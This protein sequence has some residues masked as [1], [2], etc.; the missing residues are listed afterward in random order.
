MLARSSS[1][2]KAVLCLVLPPGAEGPIIDA[3]IV[4]GATKQEQVSAVQK[5]MSVSN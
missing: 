4:S 5:A 3:E 2:T 1:R